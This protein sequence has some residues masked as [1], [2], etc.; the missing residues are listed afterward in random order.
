MIF[1]KISTNEILNIV[2]KRG[3]VLWL[4]GKVKGK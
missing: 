1:I 2:T 3:G 4:G